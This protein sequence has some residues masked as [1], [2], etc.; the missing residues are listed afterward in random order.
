MRCRGWLGR[1]GLKNYY[2]RAEGFWLIGLCIRLLY[3]RTNALVLILAVLLFVLLGV[4]I[5]SS[6]IVVISGAE[7]RI[8]ISNYL[9]LVV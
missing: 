5:F 7:I 6:N 4:D 3:L 9:I 8:L 2:V 1:Q